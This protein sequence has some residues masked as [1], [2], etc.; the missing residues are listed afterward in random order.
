MKVLRWTTVAWLAVMTACA[1]CFA[2]FIHEVL[3]PLAWVLASILIPIVLAPLFA[4]FMVTP[5]TAPVWVSLSVGACALYLW[6]LGLIGLGFIVKAWH[7]Q[8]GPTSR[9]RLPSAAMY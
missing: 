7:E 4:S 9:R 2:M 8:Q 5:G 6:L 3:L 1:A